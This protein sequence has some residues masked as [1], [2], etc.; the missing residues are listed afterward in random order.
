VD[1]GWQWRKPLRTPRLPPVCKENFNDLAGD[2]QNH[3]RSRIV[4][5]A[6]AFA[7]VRNLGRV[8]TIHNRV[9]V[10]GTVVLLRHTA[11]PDSNASPEPHEAS[12]PLSLHGD[13]G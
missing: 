11:L 3:V 13:D 4:A 9:W 5:P 12:N 2:G 1:G 7:Q 10:T 8:Y 6:I